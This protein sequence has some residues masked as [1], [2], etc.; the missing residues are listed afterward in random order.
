MR[1]APRRAALIALAID[2]QRLA[3]RLA[4]AFAAAVAPPSIAADAH[5]DFALA[6]CTCK[7]STPQ[8]L[9]CRDDSRHRRPRSGPERLQR[10]CSAPHLLW[11][12]SQ[13]SAILCPHSWPT[14]WGA[15]VG[16][17]SLSL[18]SS[19]PFLTT[20]GSSTALGPRW[21]SRMW[22]YGAQPHVAGPIG[23]AKQRP[24]LRAH[25]LQAH[26][27]Q[28]A[29]QAPP[30][31]HCVGE[32]QKVDS[33]ALKSRLFIFERLDLGL[34][35]PSW[36]SCLADPCDHRNLA[37]SLR[38]GGS[39]SLSRPGSIPMSVKADTKTDRRAHFVELNSMTCPQLI[40]C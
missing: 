39:V 6:A 16:T 3:T 30:R 29:D 24:V 28:P 21:P 9:I 27:P 34:T 38:F 7:H 37:Q 23:A 4:A 15:A 40:G 35:D 5:H 18:R 19:R 20:R 32:P 11:T 12:W 26:Q 10:S 25:P 14:R 36:P 8:R 2:V 17:T 22:G 13:S 33:A 31:G 1:Q